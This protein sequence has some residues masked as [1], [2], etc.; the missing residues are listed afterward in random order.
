[1][2]GIFVVGL[3][4]T[5][6]L[7][8]PKLAHILQK[9]VDFDLW[10]MDGDVVDIGNVERQPYQ[11]FN[12]NEKKAVALSRKIASN[13]NVS[14]YEYSDYLVGGEIENITEKQDYDKIYILGCVDNHSTRILL[15]NAYNTI[16]DCIYI[17]SANGLND[18]SIFITAS[19]SGTK[20]GTLR[21]DVFADI[22]EAK[23]HPSN[24]CITEIQKGNTQQFV[25]ND[26]MANTIAIILND[27]L[28]RKEWLGV[29][30]IE[31][32]E[33]VF[34]GYHQESNN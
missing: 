3:G 11:E 9:S 33:R 22:K 21:S 32:L 12:I 16:N 30:K 5:G 1:M 14:V 29:V 6:G 25:T 7:L 8:V 13:Y 18:G 19:Y 20:F 17:D 27:F 15:E 34:V 24:T 4:G 26:T 10:L 23:D 2:I 28:M 31:G